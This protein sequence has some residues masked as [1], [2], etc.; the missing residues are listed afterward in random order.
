MNIQS[1]MPCSR[2]SLR[3]ARFEEEMVR[4]VLKL[5]CRFSKLTPLFKKQTNKQLEV[6][7]HSLST[8]FL[9]GEHILFVW[10]KLCPASR[11]T[12]TDFSHH[13][14]LHIFLNVC[15]IIQ[16]ARYTEPSAHALPQR[17]PF[18]LGS[19]LLLVS[20]AWKS[21]AAPSPLSHRVCH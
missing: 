13:L 14:Q 15:E 18:L 4:K 20:Q 1:A 5:K 8:V 3:R 11:W 21:S 9:F 17:L 12:L 2:I 16:K 6:L 19:P 7:R 10:L